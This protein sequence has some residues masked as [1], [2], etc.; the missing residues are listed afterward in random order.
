MLMELKW[1]VILFK[2]QVSTPIP[3]RR[4]SERDRVESRVKTMNV[5]NEESPQAYSMYK[6]KRFCSENI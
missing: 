5:K 6:K 4:S 3:G 1:N 2:K